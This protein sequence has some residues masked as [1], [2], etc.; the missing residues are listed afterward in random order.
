MQLSLA[1]VTGL[2]A[3]GLAV[4]APA[5]SPPFPQDDFVKFSLTKRSPKFHH[6]DSFIID[7]DKVASHI[8]SITSKYAQTL[9]NLESNDGSKRKKR[10]SSTIGL[11]PQQQ[12]SFWSGSVQLGGQTL[13]IDFDTGSS[14]TV[15]NEG[16]YKPG[17]T[18]TK[19]SKTFQNSYGTTGNSQTVGGVVYRD[20]FASNSLK[21]SKASIGLVTSG[22]NIIDGADGLIGLAYPSISSYGSANP[23]LFD[24]LSQE[25]ALSSKVF[26]ISLSTSGGSLSLGG[27]DSTKY[28]G[29]ITYTSVSRQAYWQVPASVN[30]Q[31]FSSIV[32]SGTTLIIADTD[33]GSAQQFFRNLGVSTFTYQGDLYGKV[34]CT[35]PPKITFNY[36]GKSIT[37]TKESSIFGQTSDGNCALSI[38]GTSVGQ[39][40]WITG[41]P[42]FLSS[43]VVFDRANNRVGFADRK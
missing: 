32:D 10:A 11:T 12:Q 31:Q 1:F 33:S 9:S 19:T 41:D 21:A 39:N 23:P 24:E 43:Y 30:G 15:I 36:G 4:A 25:G 16:A 37:L 8:S 5:P 3:A 26:G 6:A 40:A 14:D 20:T 42:L 13:S 17:S 18:A 28:S 2:I 38:I 35:N 22:G 27:L 7:P 34:S 29:A